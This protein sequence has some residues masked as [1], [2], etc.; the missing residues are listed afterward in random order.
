[1]TGL[2]R[3]VGANGKRTALMPDACITVKLSH[4]QAIEAAHGLEA[5]G[6]A[7][8][9]FGT[10]YPSRKQIASVRKSQLAAKRAAALAKARIVSAQKRLAKK[11]LAAEKK[12]AEAEM[13]AASAAIK[14]ERKRAAAFAKFKKAETV[15][16][17]GRYTA[18]S[19]Q[20]AAFRAQMGPYSPMTAPAARAR[21]TKKK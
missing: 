13:K 14:A 5:S 21:R 10:D 2:R 7:Q 12:E 15:K 8:T 4:K 20:A 18:G 16:R 9:Q 19:E 17:H 3:L 1:V 11:E 6:P